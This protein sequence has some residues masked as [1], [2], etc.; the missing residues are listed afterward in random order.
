MNLICPVCNG[1][2][3]MRATCRRCSG[4][5]H[6]MGR[7]SD[8]YGDYSPYRPI[9]D[10]K[11]TNGMPDLAQHVCVHLGWCPACHEEERIAVAEMTDDEVY[12]F[13]RLEQKR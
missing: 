11:R 10:G 8:Y 1:L 12:H 5:L 7:L 2:L 3:T 9:D 13:D 4:A 6:D